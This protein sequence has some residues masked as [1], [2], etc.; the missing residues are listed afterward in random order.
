MSR[1]NGGM[2]ILHVCDGIK[3]EVAYVDHMEIILEETMYHSR[4]V[5]EVIVYGCNEADEL[6]EIG[7]YRQSTKYYT[8]HETVSNSFERM[9]ND[10]EWVETI[11]NNG[12]I[13]NRKEH[14][15]IVDTDERLC[16]IHILV[17][18]SE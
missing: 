8:L 15:V 6:Y 9:V 1:N 4:D 10:N 7:R 12:S 16:Y 14:V 13:K 17:G 11:R 18:R 3:P 5:C 2:H